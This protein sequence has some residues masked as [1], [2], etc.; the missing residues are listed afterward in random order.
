ML[1]NGKRRIMFNQSVLIVACQFSL[2]FM[3]GLQSQY[4]RDGRKVCAAITSLLLGV[5]GWN[6]TGVVASAYHSGM[7]S[8]VFYCFIFSGPAGI[9][10]SIYLHEKFNKRIK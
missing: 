5:L 9:V 6:I 10:A 1:L 8:Q 3:L 2:V 4:V 7:F